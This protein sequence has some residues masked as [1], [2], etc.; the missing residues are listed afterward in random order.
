MEAVAVIPSIPS[1]WLSVGHLPP[2]DV[3]HVDDEAQML[4]WFTE[5]VLQLTEPGR[6][7]R[8]DIS[9]YATGDRRGVYR[10]VVVRNEDWEE[11][12]LEAEAHCLAAVRVWLDEA[13][14]FVR[15]RT[16]A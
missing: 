7:Y 10:C 15:Q 14:A 13:I 1:G 9:W 11:P 16:V 6:E 4:D 12:M 5:D 2:F 3:Q 8:I